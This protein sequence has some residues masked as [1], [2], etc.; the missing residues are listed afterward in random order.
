MKRF[1]V[2]LALMVATRCSGASTP[3]GQTG[4]HTFTLG[5]N[6]FLLDGKPLQVIGREMHP[7]RIPA[8]Y[9][10][11]RIRMA[12]A[13]GCNSIAACLFWNYH[14]TAE[15]TFDFTT[16]NRDVAR[17]IRLAQ[18]EGMWVLLRPGPYVCAEWDIGPQKRLSCPAPWLKAG[19][20]EVIAFDLHKMDASPLRGA[21]TLE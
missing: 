18:A 15:G 20:N 13:L 19:T 21:P 6:D 7:A 9:W 17:F 4:T 1:A 11:H 10:A 8:E 5:T 16:G 14:D 3:A 12:K 2:G